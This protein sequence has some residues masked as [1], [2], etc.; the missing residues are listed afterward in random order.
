MQCSLRSTDIFVT[1]DGISIAKLQY[2]ALSFVL[3]TGMH[4]MTVDEIGARDVRC[5]CEMTQ[6]GEGC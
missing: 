3:S 2:E 4:D 5:F 6:T 1:G